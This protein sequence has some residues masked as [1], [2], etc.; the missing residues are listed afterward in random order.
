MANPSLKN[1]KTST[2]TTSDIACLVAKWETVYQSVIPRRFWKA[3]L[4]DF[5]GIHEPDWSRGG[6]FLAGRPGTGKTHLA[7]AL[8]KARIWPAF[9]AE[10]FRAPKIRWVSAPQFLTEIRSTFGDGK[11]ETQNDVVGRNALAD[12][13][14]L[15]DLGAEKITDWSASTLYD[16]ISRRESHMRDTIVTSNQSLKEIAEWEPRIASRLSALARIPLPDI[17]RRKRAKS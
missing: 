1:Q 11:G 2:T 8:M 4:D 16:L 6:F 17:D 13:L 9:K 3:D 7:A 15:D 5:E 14:V 10:Q 12:V